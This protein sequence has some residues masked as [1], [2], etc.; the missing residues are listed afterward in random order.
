VCV[1]VLVT[2]FCVCARTVSV[3]SVAGSDCKIAVGTV[4]S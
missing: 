2:Q 1:C 4:H 3:A